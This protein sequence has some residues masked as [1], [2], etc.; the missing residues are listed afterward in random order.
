[1]PAPT[2]EQLLRFYAEQTRRPVQFDPPLLS[3]A[4]LHEYY[5]TFFDRPATPLPPAL[6]PATIE[7][8]DTD[9]FLTEDE[10]VTKDEA[11]EAFASVQER[12]ATVDETQGVM[13]E[14]LQGL[15]SKIDE[16]QGKT[17]D[18]LRKLA[19]A[20]D[21]ALSQTSSVASDLSD[22]VAEAERQQAIVQA[23]AA[24]AQATSDAAL[25]ETATARRDQQIVHA[26]L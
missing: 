11:R 10:V 23:A 21:T 19:E 20:A 18:D 14:G 1:M 6:P 5:K 24:Q 26:Q 4:D 16:V 22:R 15:A 8:T 13:Q 17:A 7:N 9:V 2:Y 25:Q 12:F 3:Y